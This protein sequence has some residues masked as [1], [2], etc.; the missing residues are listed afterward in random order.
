MTSEGDVFD[1]FEAWAEEWDADNYR[2]IRAYNQKF[3]SYILQKAKH[4]SKVL[5]AIETLVV[6]NL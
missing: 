6:V 1:F 2:K 4:D 5:L 3:T